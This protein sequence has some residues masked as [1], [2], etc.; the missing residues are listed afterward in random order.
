MTILHVRP[1]DPVLF[2]DARPFGAASEGNRARTLPWPH[3]PTLA[4]YVRTAMGRALA[5]S[6]RPV[7]A[8]MWRKLQGT[9]AIAGPFLFCH[10]RLHLPAPADVLTVDAPDGRRRVPVRP[11]TPPEGSGTDLPPGLLPAMAAT[12][13]KVVAGERWWPHSRMA[14]WLVEGRLP[15]DDATPR[16]A[17]WGPAVD[18]RVSVALEPG[19]RRASPGLLYVT[20]GLAFAPGEEGEAMALMVWSEDGAVAVDEVLRCSQGL[21]PLGGERRLAELAVATA[22][23]GWHPPPALASRLGEAQRVRMVLATAAAFSG[24]WRP[25]WI[26]ARSLE[27]EPPGSGVRLRL[28]AASVGRAVPLSGW[29]LERRRPKGVR[30][31]AP[32]GSVYW[33]EVLPGH[34]AGPLASRW[35]TSVSDEAQDRRDGLGA[36][37]W[38][39]WQEGEEAA[40]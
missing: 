18:E 33:F 14:E 7:T 13:G 26:D 8:A 31:L 24:G 23:E 35:L 5:A 40:R 3:P 27:G 17:A 4:G 9:V 6:G 21:H 29:D 38:G 10:G 30:W 16:A 37:V 34:S 11:D 32:A 25:G 28:V 20:Q 36:A 19:T 22:T 2:R 39:V 12:Q 15:P 1:R